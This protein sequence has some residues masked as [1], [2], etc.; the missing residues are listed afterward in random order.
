VDSSSVGKEPFLQRYEE[1][2]EGRSVFNQSENEMSK[3]L[4]KILDWLFRED[5]K[6]ENITEAC[7]RLRIPPPSKI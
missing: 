2:T 3:L 6:S 5:E 7:D 1:S 4:D